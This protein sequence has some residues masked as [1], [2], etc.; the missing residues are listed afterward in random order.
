MSSIR[1]LFSKTDLARF[2]ILLLIMLGGSLLELASLGAVPLFVSLLMN[3]EKDSKAAGFLAHIIEVLHLPQT[4][5]LPLWGAC[6]LGLLFLLRTVYLVASYAIQ[7]HV[8][9]NR[10]IAIACRLFNAYMNAPYS[11][12][13]RHNSSTFI[14][15]V[16]NEVDNIVHYVLNASLNLARNAI[17]LTAIVILLLWYNPIVCVGCF[18]TL[19]IAAGGFFLCTRKRLNAIG[20]SIYARKQDM[21]KVLSEGIGA[22]KEAQLLDRKDF[23]RGRLHTAVQELCTLTKTYALISRSTWPFMELITC[24]VILGTMGIMLALRE[25]VTSI[26][27]SIALV[28]ACLARLKGTITEM[29]IF[30]EYCKT[31]QSVINSIAT[32]L[33]ELERNYPPLH[34]S[35]PLPQLSFHDSISVKGIDFRYE[36]TTKDTLHDVSFTIPCGKSLAFVG[37]TGSGKTT[38]ANIIVALLAPTRGEIVVDGLAIDTPQAIRTWQD[39]I[40][41]VS[42]D[43]FLMDDSLRSNIAFGIQE[44]DIDEQKLQYA[45]DAAQL[46]PF[47][48]SLPDKLDTFVG[49]RGIRLSGGQRQRIAIARALY[50]NPPFLV[51]DEATSA[52]DVTTEHAIVDALNSLHGTHTIVVIAHRLSTVQHCDRIIYLKDG[53]IA[54]SGTYEELKISLPDFNQMT[55]N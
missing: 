20:I 1:I 38:L 29:M 50:L 34:Q 13:L 19:A 49:E 11:Y 22:Y 40:G 45:I 18:T 24:M 5:N 8:V 37:P 36:G 43:V 47:I 55:Q 6:A 27:P 23:F 41:Y 31:H 25:N 9:Q 17:I 4:D 14:N 33:A 7:E 53:S 16:Q 3:P 2:G 39:S 26:A 48:D 35:T 28:T 42:Q 52:L 12:H 21:L 46:R 51:F 15:N 30:A 54:G 32:E 44:K 10:H